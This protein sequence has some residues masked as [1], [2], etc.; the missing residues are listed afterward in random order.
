MNSYTDF[1]KKKSCQAFLLIFLI[2]FLLFIPA[3]AQKA[4]DFTL[5]DLDGN[6][7]RLSNYYQKNVILLDFWATRCLPCIKELS[8]IQKFYEKYKEKG[9]KIFAISVDTPG[10]I[11]NVKS[12]V[13]RYKYSF[14][15]LLDT[16]SKV[17]ALYNPRMILPYTIL[18]NMEGNIKFVHQGFSPGDENFLEQKII[19]LLKPKEKVK[20]KK[21]SYHTN[22][23][24]LIRNFSDKDY[25]KQIREGRTFQIINQFNL[26]LTGGD[27]ILGIRFDSYLDF[28]PLKEK[29]SLA[30]RFLEVNKRK[31]S[32]RVG[33]FYY[34]IGR[35]LILSVLK[36][37]EEEGLEYMIDTTVEG[38]KL[39]LSHGQFSA[40][41]FGGWIDRKDS[42]LKDKILGGA[43][44]WKLNGS[45][46]LQF[47]YLYSQLEEGS[48][49][50]NKKVYIESINLDVHKISN[51]AKFYGEFALI[52]KDNY[53]SDDRINGHG[54]YL[55]SGIF[56][57][58]FTLLLEFKDYNQL[59][60]E[61]NRP[62]LLESEQLD[63]LA[64]QFDTDA[65][66]ITGISGRIDY[67]SPKISTLI[68]G[69]VSYT[70][71]SPETFII[72]LTL[73]IP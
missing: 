1:L 4:I 53:Y 11:A 14:P 42:D 69:K 10:T 44:N 58:N 54:L 71:D 28:S 34:S 70:K 36:T 32:L 62:P 7:T 59:N 15:V 38:G 64:N 9:L 37:F 40:E 13:N 50:G 18:I 33:D 47:N 60:Y 51:Y 12:F 22:E 3:S 19:E 57:G 55:E 35:G 30:K 72:N 49:F 27:Y 6:L 23:A 5:K 41:F 16:E 56:L 24:L 26:S 39:G 52:Q 65:T 73:V 31:F 21:F 45:A 46:N 20:I 61:Y 67:Y 29:F 63:I 25:V 17:V 2:T 43:I 48:N 68:Y 66:D 8:H